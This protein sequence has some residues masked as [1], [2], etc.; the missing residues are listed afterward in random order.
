M[1]PPLAG[2][3]VVALGGIGPG[4]FG[5]L[6]LADLGADVI[7]VERPG[8]PERDPSSAVFARGCRSIVLDLADPDALQSALRLVDTADA[9]IEGFRPG[10]A[11]RL[12]IGPVTC[13][14][15]NPRLIYARVTGWGQEGPLAATAGHDLNYIGLTGALHAIG[16]A[17]RPPVPPLNLVGDFGGGGTFVALGILAALLERT[18]SGCGQVL[19][20]AMVDGVALLA[21]VFQPLVASGYWDEGRRGA[22]LLDG[23]AHFYGVYETSDGGY[24]SVASLEPQFYGE[25]LGH[26]GLDPAEWPQGD[27]S[28][29]SELRERLAGVFRSRTRAEWEAEFAGSDACVAPVLTFTEA[30]VHEH[31]REREGYVDVGGVE[32]PRP[33]PRF[34]RTPLPVPAAAPPAGADTDELLRELGV[35]TEHA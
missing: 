12:G 11:E 30:R 34:A 32:Q 18:R 35:V 10:V 17:D 5:A 23:G 25:L 27:R 19:D 8:G 28:R 2:T 1:T 31:A 21:S 26:L 33:A 24:M 4:P 14:E 6:L 20:V 3:R 15:R 22:N 29:W 13:L 7:R 16:E 9:L